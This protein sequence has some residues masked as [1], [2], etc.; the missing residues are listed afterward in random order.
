M[1]ELSQKNLTKSE[2]LL[3]SSYR[4]LNH[5]LNVI[6]RKANSLFRQKLIKIFLLIFVFLLISIIFFIVYKSKSYK[7][8]GK[9]LYENIK[10]EQAL[11]KYYEAK[12]WY[13]FEV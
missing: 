6:L 5:Y 4:K 8:E 13:L 12:K 9:L 10:Y 3:L 1:K 2:T 7:K 11:E